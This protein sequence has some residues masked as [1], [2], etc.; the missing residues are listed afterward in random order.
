MSLEIKIPTPHISAKKDEIA[1][2]VI[3][4]GDPLRAKWIAEKFLEK[5]KLVSNVRASRIYTGIYKGKRISVM[6]HGMGMPSASIY[7]YEIIKFYNVKK[8]IRLGTCGAYKKH[9]NVG[10]VVVAKDV[11]TRSNFWNSFGLDKPFK[12]FNCNYNF[13]L[14]TKEYAQKSNT[15]IQQ[16]VANSSDSFYSINEKIWQENAEHCDV[17]EME[18][19]A[20]YTIATHFNIEA[21]MFLTISD[22]Y[23]EGR[24][25]DHKERE[26][27]LTKMIK[28]GLEII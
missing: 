19:Y 11:W 21:I 27:G 4:C 2:S 6:S 1:S 13:L 3:I 28:I 10:D 9:L 14:K 16:V 12:K 22:S 18:G 8:I 23:V 17:T 24:V 7:I 15:I 5:Y 25:M 26:K 20:L